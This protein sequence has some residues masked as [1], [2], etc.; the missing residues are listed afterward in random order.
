MVISP[1]KKGFL[2]IPNSLYTFRIYLYISLIN[3]FAWFWWHSSL[4]SQNYYIAMWVKRQVWFGDTVQISLV[5]ESCVL[6]HQNHAK[7]INSEESRKSQEN[8]Y[9]FSFDG[10]PYLWY[11]NREPQQH[12]REQAKFQVYLCTVQIQFPRYTNW[13]YFA[14]V[15]NFKTLRPTFQ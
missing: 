3:I 5:L 8:F 12:V 14:K 9:F 1:W 15:K 11:S 13:K 7:I 6:C 2:S 10:L 4:D